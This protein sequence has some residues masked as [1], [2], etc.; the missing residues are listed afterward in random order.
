MLNVFF[1]LRTP[2]LQ[3]WIINKEYKPTSCT[4]TC[5]RLHV[6]CSKLLITPRAY[7]K[8][9][10]TLHSNECP[11]MHPGHT[12]ANLGPAAVAALWPG[13]RTPPPGVIWLT[14]ILLWL[15]FCVRSQYLFYTLYLLYC[16][17][18]LNPHMQPIVAIASKA[19]T[20]GDL[21]VFCTL[22]KAY[23]HWNEL[24]VLVL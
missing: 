13:G 1:S 3:D 16:V 8:G 11:I 14:W 20:H 24:R 4:T 5:T 7:S 23:V 21:D 10:L 12:V 22:R 18:S 2:E 17:C 19:K 15:T 6:E 9:W